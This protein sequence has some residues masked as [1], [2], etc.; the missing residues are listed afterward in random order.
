MHISSQ[1]LPC[2]P[3]CETTSAE[4]TVHQ[5]K[6]VS[7]AH[8]NPT[9][10]ER[11]KADANMHHVI[12]YEGK[13]TVISP[14]RPIFMLALACTIPGNG[15]FTVTDNMETIMSPC[16]LPMFTCSL[17]PLLSSNNDWVLQGNK[18]GTKG[19]GQVWGNNQCTT[20]H[21]RQ[22]AARR[23]TNS[24]SAPRHWTQRCGRSFLQ[25]AQSM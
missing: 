12:L 2:P 5:H 13:G 6:R 19:G 20:K 16:G 7:I 8:L 24:P 23:A 9:K 25:G 4:T 18:E 22:K 17:Y 10:L 14:L 1:T 21:K 15:P 3:A 11:A